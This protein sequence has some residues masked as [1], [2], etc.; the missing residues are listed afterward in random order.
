MNSSRISLH[1]ETYWV[2]R[3]R[4]SLKRMHV[5]FNA[6]LT[7]AEQLK[8]VITEIVIMDQLLRMNRG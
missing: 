6:L 4:V 8:G 7:T 3:G 1:K 2:S 5:A